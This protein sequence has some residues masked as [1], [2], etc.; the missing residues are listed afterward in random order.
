[1]FVIW[2]MKLSYHTTIT[3]Y[4]NFLNYFMKVCSKTN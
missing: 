2:S 4:E 1:M 3:N